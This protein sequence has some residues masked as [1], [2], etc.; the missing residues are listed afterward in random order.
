MLK[1]KTIVIGVSGGIAVYKVCD[2]VSKL[3]KLNADVHVIMTESATEFVAPLTFE[4]L[5][6]QPVIVDMFAKIVKWDIEHIALAKAADLF[7][8]A[9]AT[10]NI[11]GKIANGIADDM[12]STTI[13]ATKA[14]KIIAPA[15]NTNM[16]E[17]PIV[18][19][20][21][22]KLKNY[23]Y[24]FIKPDSGRLACGDL[25]IG[26]LANVDTIIESITMNLIEDKPLAGQKILITAG[27]T[28]EA[29]D[30]VRYMTNHSSGK[31]GY[32]IAEAAAV[33]GAEVTLISGP[34]TLEKPNNLKKYIQI[35]SA[36]EMF[37]AV[38]D[39]LKDQNI[40]IKSAAVADYRP[41]VYVDKKIK[42]SDEDFKL[43]LTRNPDILKWIGMHKTP[44]QLI[45]GFAA[46]T[47]DVMENGISKLKKKNIDMIIVNDVTRADAGFGTDTNC[48]TLIDKKGN[49]KAYPVMPKKQLAHS[50]LDYIIANF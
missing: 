24:K 13:M 44:E 21:I 25:G 14:P 28:R 48:V 17:N 1:G 50:I 5:S 41:E 10:A 6:L 38:K 9:P 36:E 12:L 40:I 45:V 3:K 30:P 7:L 37:T 18:Q 4:S 35:E 42:K 27:P 47:N 15:M 2:L 43:T 22:K 39:N 31:M 26:K 16:Y 32:A 34:V 11:I 33:K 49:K 19:D 29:L 8:V 46:E 20:N 23:G